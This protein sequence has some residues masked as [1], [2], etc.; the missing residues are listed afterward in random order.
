MSLLQFGFKK[1][2]DLDLDLH[3]KSQKSFSETIYSNKKKKSE[4]VNNHELNS[5]ECSKIERESSILLKTKSSSD[6]YSKK[7][8]SESFD[9]TK[10]S[11]INS[12]NSSVKKPRK[13]VVQ[14]SDEELFSPNTD[15]F[16]IKKHNNNELGDSDST[17]CSFLLKNDDSDKPKKVSKTLLSTI[18]SKNSDNDDVHDLSFSYCT[19]KGKN[20]SSSKSFDSSSKKKSHSI[21]KK[22]DLFNSIETKLDVLSLGEHEHHNLPWLKDNKIRDSQGLRLDEDGYD[23]RT[24]YVPSGY[25]DG[26]A[27]YH[28]SNSVRKITPASRMWWEFKSKYN[29]VIL[30][31]KVG[32]FYEVY[33]MDADIGVKHLSLVYMKG[34][35]AHCGFPEKSYGKF[36][37][38]LV[39]L[40]YRVA[41]IE[42]TETPEANKIRTGKSSGTLRRELCGILS[43]GTRT[44]DVRD[45]FI[46]NKNMPTKIKLIALYRLPETNTNELISDKLSLF[47]MCI[48]D[49]TTGKF[50]L[51]KFYDTANH[52]CLRMLLTRENPAELVFCP[53]NLLSSTI[54]LINQFFPFQLGVTNT[55]VH[56]KLIEIDSVKCVLD[57]LLSSQSSYFGENNH[58]ALP[59]VIQKLIENK[60]L[61]QTSN[62]PELSAFGMVFQVIQRHKICRRLLSLRNFSF[63]EFPD[64]VTRNNNSKDIAES[65]QLNSDKFIGQKLILD[66]QA[67][68]NLDLVEGFLHN[69]TTKDNNNGTLL[70]FLDQCVT[71]FGKREIRSWILAPLVCTNEI[72]SRQKKVKALVYLLSYGDIIPKLRQL[73]KT[74]PDLE[75]MILR[76]HTVGLKDPDHPDSRAILYDFVEL[77]KGKISQLIQTINGARVSLQA[78]ELLNEAINSCITVTK[79]LQEFCD[80]PFKEW[81]SILDEFSHSFNQETAKETGSITP[82]SGVNHKYDKAVEAVYNCK[83]SFDHE[84]LEIR[85]YYKG[86]DGAKNIKLWSPNNGKD[87]FQIEI[88]ESLLKMRELPKGYLFKTHSKSTKVKRFF[89]SQH[90]DKLNMLAQA[91]QH[92]KEVKADTTRMVFEQFDSR[93]DI[94]KRLVNIVRDLDCLI[95][96]AIVSSNTSDG[97]TMCLPEVVDPSVD[98]SHILELRSSQHPC[99]ARILQNEG[100]SYIQNDITLG[101]NHP[102]CI[103]LTGPNMGGKSSLCRQTAIAIIMAQIGCYVNAEFAQ[104]TPVDRIFTRLG[105]SDFIM[106]G[107]S[108]FFVEL[109]EAATV[110]NHATS[111]SFIILDE[112]GRGTSTYDGTAIAYA[113]IQKLLNIRA[114]TIFATHYHGLIKDFENDSRVKIC[115]MACLAQP[116]TQDDP[117]KEFAD[118]TFLYKMLDGPSDKSHGLNVARLANL[119]ESIIQCAQ[120]QSQSF[121]NSFLRDQL[122]HEIKEVV[123]NHSSS[124]QSK[125][126][127]EL[128]ERARKIITIK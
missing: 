10:S 18:S 122:F 39:Q 97:S 38:Q 66:S 26:K 48:M 56:T 72:R 34:D 121:E 4:S 67:M 50:H 15:E 92:L 6:I 61:L 42:Q 96:L 73:F 104:I 8:T 19:P 109:D 87:L 81:N 127:S 89:S 52:A 80:I 70:S 13:T 49:S 100:K 115:H 20:G 118:V 74:L 90:V 85:E 16:Q 112:L 28:C 17:P 24:L 11:V 45:G 91:E 54:N 84:L 40:G 93:C 101:G 117:E 83:K 120:K 32:K 125:I 78:L 60:E 3:L 2:K 103:L 69:S 35:V 123:M 86:I 57:K 98:K 27:Q 29:D 43:A 105:A 31:F 36:S 119:P 124:D 68:Y 82:H 71:P 51:G 99:I 102:S 37:E 116:K 62:C 65:V 77:N 110:L 41:R 76:I 111:R 128:W 30:F 94:Y 25:Y 107:E 114:R 21:E 75:R 106:S 55:I 59:L 1:K 53:S 79:S 126:L 44:L 9:P 46:H 64:T 88:P 33:H 7:L 14:S 95:S 23:Y 63:Y 47:G 12:S 58:S 22:L 108:T 5:L 113:V